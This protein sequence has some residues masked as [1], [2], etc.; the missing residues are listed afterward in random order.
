MQGTVARLAVG[1]GKR[2]N[3]D[4]AVAV[5][6]E[7]SDDPRLLG[8]VLGIYLA[9]LEQESPGYQAAVDLLRYAGADE[10]VA[11]EMLE[12]QRDRYERQ[13]QGG[14]SL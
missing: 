2:V 11:A 10:R 3:A 7:I 13:Q 12:W 4:E 14:F 5:L 6:H 1:V 8:H 9:R